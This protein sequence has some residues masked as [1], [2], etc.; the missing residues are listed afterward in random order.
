MSRAPFQVLVLP[1]RRNN[2]G[3]LE[4][5]VFKRLIGEY[6]QFIAGGG[7]D[8]ETPI[9]AARRETF[10]ETGIIPDLEFISLDTSNTIPVVDV[11]GEFTWGESVLVIPEYA[12]GIEFNQTAIKLS[13][14]H[15]EFRWVK[16]QEG[17]SLL[18]W[19]SNRNA[20]WEL[21][22]RLNRKNKVID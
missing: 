1:Y 20:L 5:A 19:D 4:Y 15:T 8:D 7:Q 12:F 16:Y 6:W 10:E 11:T 2:D 9:Q 18:K 22:V 14:E 3:Q 13:K 21:N 17:I